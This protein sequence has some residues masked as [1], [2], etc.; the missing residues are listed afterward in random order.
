MG[1]T[2]GSLINMSRISDITPIVLNL[3][4]I[5]CSEELQLTQ[6]SSENATSTRLV[7]SNSVKNIKI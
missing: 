7:V 1:S 3:S 2:S 4:I 5:K 6:Y